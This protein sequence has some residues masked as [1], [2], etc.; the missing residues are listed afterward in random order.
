MTSA[1]RAKARTA[2]IK[3]RGLCIRCALV[4]SRPGLTTCAPCAARHTKS[5]DPHR[6]RAP[7][8]GPVQDPDQW[9]LECGTYQI[10]RTGC[11]VRR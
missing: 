3:A 9:C 1:Q 2:R 11:P 4:K 7:R 5:Q 8:P 10:H 6:V